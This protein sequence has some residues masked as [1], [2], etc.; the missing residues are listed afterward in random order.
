MSRK[1]VPS[2]NCSVRTRVVEIFQCICRDHDRRLCEVDGEAPRVL[3]L[4]GVV[5]LAPDDALEL[6]HEAVDV[7]EDPA[8]EPR[9]Q[10]VGEL[11]HELQVRLD[12]ARRLGPLHLD[13]DDLPAVQHSPVDLPDARRA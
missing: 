1:R 13:R 5:Q 6:R 11:P 4:G 9:V 8:P 10:E 2:M 12:P 3:R 7:H